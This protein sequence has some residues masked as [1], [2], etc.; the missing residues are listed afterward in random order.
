MSN[1]MKLWAA[2]LGA[3]LLAG[4]ASETTSP[5][6]EIVWVGGDAAHLAADKDACQKESVNVDYNSAA[7]YSDPRYGPTSA[8][9]AQIN[10]D[11]P[12]SDQH[13]AVRAA[14]MAACMTDKGWKPQE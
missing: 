6:P 1:G 10:R 3:S 5:P 12:L 4:C 14:A 13:A 8:M 7:G 11:R 9:A 2:I